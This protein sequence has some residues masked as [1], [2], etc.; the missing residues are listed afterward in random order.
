M[1]FF[2]NLKRPMRQKPT[3]IG[4]KPELLEKGTG[5]EKL[6]PSLPPPTPPPPI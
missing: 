3:K 6:E 2:G 4:P 5:R 1:S